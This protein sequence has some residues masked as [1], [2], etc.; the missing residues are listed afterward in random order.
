[1]QAVCALQTGVVSEELY[2]YNCGAG[3]SSCTANPANPSCEGGVC[4]IPPE[5]RPFTD[6]EAQT[7]FAAFS[8]TSI[9]GSTTGG[10]SASMDFAPVPVGYWS[11][12]DTEASNGTGSRAAEENQGFDFSSLITG[13]EGSIAQ[14]G[15]QERCKDCR[16]FE[17]SLVAVTDLTRFNP[18][19][20]RYGLCYRFN[21]FR[22]DYLQIA[23]RS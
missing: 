11:C 3:G 2:S 18:S 14:F 15:G 19:F 4:A 17:S 22:P 8:L 7:A 21:C 9:S 13:Q 23:I 12:L 1:M 6:A 10:F 16:C 5:Q 20:P